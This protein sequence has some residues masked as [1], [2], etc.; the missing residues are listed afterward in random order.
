MEYQQQWQG[1]ASGAQDRAGF[2]RS[3]YL[4]LLGGIGVAAL[5]AISAPVIGNAL[6]PLAG[7]FFGW[8][9]FGVQFGTLLFASRVRRRQPLNKVAYALF[10]YVSGVIAGIV[11]LVVAA[12]AGFQPVLLAFGMTGAAFSSLTA[13]AFV[14]KKDFSFLRNF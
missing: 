4:W 5:G 7:N 12:G 3:V 6:A 11:A 13:V 2:V 10:T 1:I 8:L 9:L 14:T